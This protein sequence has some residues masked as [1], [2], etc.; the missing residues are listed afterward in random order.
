MKNIIKY[1]IVGIVCLVIGGLITFSFTKNNSD[2]KLK[3]LPKPEVTGGQRG[4]LG[5]DK[6]INEDTIDEYLGREDSVYRD[7]RML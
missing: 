5:I 4:Q 3:D 2:S 6:N 7:V 1:V